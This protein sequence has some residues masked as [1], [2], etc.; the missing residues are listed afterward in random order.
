MTACVIQIL[1]PI[2]LL[3]SSLLANWHVHSCLRPLRLYLRLQCRVAEARILA[4]PR[5]C[6]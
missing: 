5:P 1:V 2:V 4:S 6:V 3:V